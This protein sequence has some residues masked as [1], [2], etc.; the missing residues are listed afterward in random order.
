MLRIRVGT[1]TCRKC[2]NINAVGSVGDRRV[3]ELRLI[4]AHLRVGSGSIELKEAGGLV[5]TFFGQLTW[6]F[7]AIRIKLRR[8]M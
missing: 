7:V 3:I 1:M 5:A 8:R 2:C 6:E 4:K